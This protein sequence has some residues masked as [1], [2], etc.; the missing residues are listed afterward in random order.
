MNIA[1]VVLLTDIFKSVGIK[2]TKAYYF[3]LI[4][5]ASVVSTFCFFTIRTIKTSIKNELRT[6]LAY[7]F[8]CRM[9]IFRSIEHKL[10]LVSIEVV[11]EHTV[12]KL[13]DNIHIAHINLLYYCFLYAKTVPTKTMGEARIGVAVIANRGTGNKILEQF[14][15]FVKT[16]MTWFHYE[17]CY[18]RT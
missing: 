1:T 17:V 10:R 12:L 6:F 7:I 3:I 15:I 2:S 16:F 9:K 8:R 13:I 18:E 11:I 4:L 14:G 5:Q